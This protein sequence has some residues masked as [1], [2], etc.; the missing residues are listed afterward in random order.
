MS[1]G[2]AL[3][4]RFTFLGGAYSRTDDDGDEIWAFLLFHF[5]SAT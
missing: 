1:T 2:A 4:D 3:L 5:D